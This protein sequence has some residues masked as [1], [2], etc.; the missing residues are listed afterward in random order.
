MFWPIVEAV[1]AAI[2]AKY[3]DQTWLRQNRIVS[4]CCVES[5]DAFKNTLRF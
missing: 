3:F 4:E 5:N 2:D 1:T